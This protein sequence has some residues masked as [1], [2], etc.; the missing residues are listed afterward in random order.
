MIKICLKQQKGFK[1]T[2]KVTLQL[3]SQTRR[4][5]NSIVRLDFFQNEIV[6]GKTIP[7]EFEIFFSDENGKL[8]SDVQLIIADSTS[9][10]VKMRT[11]RKQFSMKNMT[12]KRENK[13]YLNIQERNSSN[14]PE[15]IEF[16]INIAFT[17]DF[18]F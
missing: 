3:L 8:I 11:Y 12:Y 16:T 4:V 13:Y 6:G 15:R 14:L 10:D 18:G 9:D 5:S 1:S 7:N 17:D 2:N